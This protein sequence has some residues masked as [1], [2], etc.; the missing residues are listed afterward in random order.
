MQQDDALL[1]SRS[2]KGDLDAFNLIVDRYQ[3]QVYHQAARVLG[4]RTAAEDAA[5]EAFISAYGAI[6]RFRGGSLRAWLYRI[7]TNICY[8][9]MRA[10]RRA[11]EQSLDQSLLNPAFQVPSTGESPE[12]QVLSSELGVEIQHAIAS[13]PL[14]QRATL[15]MVDVQG[16]SYEEAAEAAEVSIGTIKSRLSRARSRARD[17]LRQHRELLPEQFRQL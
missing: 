12:Q 13:L 15:V 16:L 14:D 4:D 11:P 7:V 5:Q 2:K 10:R 8:D 9:F 1:V 3:T 6:G 17:Y